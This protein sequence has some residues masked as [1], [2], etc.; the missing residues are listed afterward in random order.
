MV[1]IK[2]TAPVRPAYF[3]ASFLSIIY[4]YLTV[5]YRFYES[6]YRLKA[7][8]TANPPGSCLFIG[9]FDRFIA[10]FTV[11]YSKK[12]GFSQL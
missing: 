10:D 6:F 4:Q 1:M 3:P 5:I 9:V 8:I 11:H 2:A 12:S 7:W